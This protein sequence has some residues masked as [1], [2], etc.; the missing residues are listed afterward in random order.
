[1]EKLIIPRTMYSPSGQRKVV[2]TLEE[3]TQLEA[4]GWSRRRPKTTN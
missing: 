2:N 4:E 1:M 3:K